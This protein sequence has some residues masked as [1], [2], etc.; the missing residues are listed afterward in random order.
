MKFKDFLSLKKIQCVFYFKERTKDECEFQ[1]RF[2]KI[3][4]EFSCGRFGKFSFK[5][6]FKQKFTSKFSKC[7]FQRKFKCEFSHICKFCSFFYDD[8]HACVLVFSFP[9]KFKLDKVKPKGFWC[10]ALWFKGK[11][12]VAKCSIHRKA[13]FKFSKSGFKFCKA[14][15]NLIKSKKNLQKQI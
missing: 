8:A 4:R 1:A 14:S 11:I 6:K 2:G 7:K 13:K 10:F 5:C 9:Q 3:W 15:L 12:K